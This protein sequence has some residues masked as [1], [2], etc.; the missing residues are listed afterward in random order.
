M[1]NAQTWLDP[2]TPVPNHKAGACRALSLHTIAGNSPQATVS[3]RSL[4]KKTPEAHCLPARSRAPW[5]GIQGFAQSRAFL[6]SAAADASWNVAPPVPVSP[7][8]TPFGLGGFAHSPPSAWSERLSICPSKPIGRQDRVTDSQY[9]RFSHRIFIHSA[10]IVHHGVGN[11][12]PE[13]RVKQT[14][15]R[16]CEL[17]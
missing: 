7:P 2:G 14:K 6:A 4:L 16:G 11:L 1:A 13:E 15:S 10:P 9:V 5:P 12:P 8:G 17:R 3:G